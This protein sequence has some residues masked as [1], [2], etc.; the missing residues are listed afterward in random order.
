MIDL[1]SL[2]LLRPHLKIE[3]NFV[4]DGITEDLTA[5]V[6]AITTAVLISS[7]NVDFFGWQSVELL[8]IE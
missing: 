7:V 8:A 1:N 4:L 3:D 5:K 2:F 6:T